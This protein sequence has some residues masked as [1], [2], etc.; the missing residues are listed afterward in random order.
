MKGA[1]LTGLVILSAVGC[2][3]AADL[4]FHSRMA[5][6][7][8][9]V[10][11]NG[12]Y[13]PPCEWTDKEDE[14]VLWDY[15]KSEVYGRSYFGAPP[16]YSFYISSQAGDDWC[17]LQGVTHEYYWEYWDSLYVPEGQSVEKDI[18][19]CFDDTPTRGR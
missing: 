2:F 13:Q 18:Y 7:G 10:Y 6:A 12:H 5:C 1:I 15:E 9:L 4:Y 8:S 17:W 11:G 19:F 16:T 3:V 14:A